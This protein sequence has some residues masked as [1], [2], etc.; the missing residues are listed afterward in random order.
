MDGVWGVEKVCI[1]V[2]CNVMVLLGKRLVE[3][4]AVDGPEGTD[5]S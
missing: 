1:R 3:A 4:I 2:V 5:G